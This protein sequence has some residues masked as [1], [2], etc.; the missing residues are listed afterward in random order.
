MGLQKG[1][2]MLNLAVLFGTI[3]FYVA[4]RFISNKQY[5]V[6]LKAK[7]LELKKF[8]TDYMIEPDSWFDEGDRK[9]FLNCIENGIFD[10][11]SVSDME[12]A[13]DN[14]G[15]INWCSR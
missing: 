14:R 4:Y 6:H 5:E 13:I 3:A 12:K 2:A 7:R 8:V 1:R 10:S 9:D 15:Y 11:F